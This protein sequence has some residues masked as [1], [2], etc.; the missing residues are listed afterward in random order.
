M[1]LT[2]ERFVIDDVG[3]KAQAEVESQNWTSL[4][5]ALFRRGSFSLHESQSQIALISRLICQLKNEE[6][7]EQIWNMLL[8]IEEMSTK[9]SI[10]RY[11]LKRGLGV[12][13]STEQ[14]FICCHFCEIDRWL[15]I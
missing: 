14:K 8:S 4:I 9:N 3:V 1:D 12:E 13:S 10:E 15:R 5:E 2:I 11:R 6:I 7:S